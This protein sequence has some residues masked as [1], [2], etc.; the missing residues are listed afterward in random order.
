MG[1]RLQALRAAGSPS[2]ITAIGEPGPTREERIA[3][4]LKEWRALADSWEID[5]DIAVQNCGEDHD[6]VHELAGDIE[7]LREWIRKLEEL[8]QPGRS[9][10]T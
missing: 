10:E 4:T 9:K 7:G 8:A 5:H 1:K 6:L 2:V 3:R